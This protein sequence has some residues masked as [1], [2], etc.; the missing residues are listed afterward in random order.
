MILLTANDTL[1]IVTP[2]AA[3]STAPLFV[4]SYFDATAGVISAEGNRTGTIGQ[5]AVNVLLTPTGAVVRHL[6][7]FYLPNLAGTPVTV[8]ILL[9]GV[10]LFTANLSVGDILQYEKSGD[11]FVVVDVT[12]ARKQA[13]PAQSTGFAPVVA[14]VA[15]TALQTGQ[16][17]YLNN[18]GQFALASCSS[19][20]TSFAS[21]LVMLTTAQGFVANLTRDVLTM[22]DWSAVA[23]VPYLIPGQRYC[24]AI[25]PGSISLS[26]P[27]TSGQVVVPLGQ[28][29][30]ATQFLFRPNQP[31]LL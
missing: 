17:V 9:N 24:L 3:L 21:G 11:G 19:L 2:S 25:A 6:S 12:G 18:G 29:L 7:S 26:A 28:A 20:A 30:S 13:S 10:S 5:G 15:A 27:Q 8:Q 22:G 23:G 1:Q 14:A 4:A 16:V 31:I